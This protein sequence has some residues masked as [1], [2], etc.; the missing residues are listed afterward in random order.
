MTRQIDLAMS[1][2]AFAHLSARPSIYTLT[3]EHIEIFWRNFVLLITIRRLY[4]K[5]VKSDNYEKHKNPGNSEQQKMQKNS[6]LLTTI[7]LSGN[8][9]A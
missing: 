5:W 6:Y 9:A 3:Q 4:F 8:E 7:A 1:V 2:G